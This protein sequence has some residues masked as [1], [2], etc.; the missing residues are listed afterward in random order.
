MIRKGNPGLGLVGVV[1]LGLAGCATV[2]MVVPQ[3]LIDARAALGK[4]KKTE[5]HLLAAEDYQT[6]KRLL[7]RA[8]AAFAA[9]RSMTIVE[10]TAF[11]AEAYA[12][13]AEARAC[14]RRAVQEYEYIKRTIITRQKRFTGL[15]RE[16]EKRRTIRSKV[17]LAKPDKKTETSLSVPVE[18]KAAL[19]S[20]ARKLKAAVVRELAR[21]IAISF[22]GRVLFNPGSSRLQADANTLL[23]EVAEVIKQFPDYQIRIEGHTDNIGDLLAN[24]TLSQAQAESVL[25]YLN[26]KSISLDKLAAVGIGPNR[27]KATNETP[28]GRELNQRLEIILEKKEN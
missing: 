15:A 5:A 10:N 16:E 4:A 7:E 3:V 28:E 9:E 20:Q 14:G 2:P 11:E 1:L 13:I 27:P 18:Y 23:D 19:L 25:T 26:R 17:Q 12:R 24:N 21:G 22:P 8:E 6:A